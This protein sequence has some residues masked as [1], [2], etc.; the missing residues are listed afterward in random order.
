MDFDGMGASQYGETNTAANV[1]FNGVNNFTVETW[2]KNPGVSNG[3]NNNINN[4][5]TI[6]IYSIIRNK[7]CALSFYIKLCMTDITRIHT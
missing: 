7:W 6:I 2:Y 4:Q 3:P 5:G 1:I